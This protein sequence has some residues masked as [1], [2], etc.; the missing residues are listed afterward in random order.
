LTLLHAGDVTLQAD[1][2]RVARRAAAV[3]H[4]RTP[5]ALHQLV[6]HLIAVYAPTAVRRPFFVV[7]RASAA[8]DSR[9][10]RSAAG[11]VATGARAAGLI[12][13]GDSSIFIAGLK[14]DISNDERKKETLP[15]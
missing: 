3:F 9:Q 2:R 1:R 4:V 11:L 8:L 15:P 5:A 13:Q 14:K 10:R 6:L 12:Y 7:R